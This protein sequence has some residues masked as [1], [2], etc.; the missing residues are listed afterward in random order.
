MERRAF[1][2]LTRHITG[3]LPLAVLSVLLLVAL[4]MMNAATQ[5]SAF[6]GRWYSWLLLG[7]V[8]G[9]VMLMALILF[10]VFRL[11][12]QYRVGALGSRLTL[13]LVIIFVLL[14]V[15]PVAVVFVF[16]V[17]TVNRGLDT[18]FD[19]KIEQAL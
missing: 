1:A 4:M 13:R 10:N 15:L 2:E 8:L 6:F 16:S 9:I 17:Q 7:N 18:W 5:N 19:V 11:V 3:W 12:D 14:S